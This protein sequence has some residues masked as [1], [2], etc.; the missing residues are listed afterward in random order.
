MH[1]DLYRA[2]GVILGKLSEAYYGQL[3]LFGE[4][5]R[6][7]R[8]S[9]LYEG[10]D[11]LRDKYGKHTVFLGA[12]FLAHTHAQHDGARGQLPERQRVLLPGETQRKRLGIPMFM[13]RCASRWRSPTSL[14]Y[15]PHPLPDRR[16]PGATAGD[17]TILEISHRCSARR[18]AWGHRAFITGG[19]TMDQEVPRHESVPGAAPIDAGT[20]VLVDEGDTTVRSNPRTACAPA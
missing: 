8:L 2:T 12:S 1:N 16:G 10:V 7:Q 5:L 19:P 4:V 20:A 13:G 3:D 9:H 14:L 15:T 11:T 17:S 18:V 6:L